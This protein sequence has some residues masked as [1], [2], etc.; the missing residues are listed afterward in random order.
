[1]P[2]ASTGRLP[3]PRAASR[4]TSDGEVHALEPRPGRARSQQRRKVELARGIMRDH[5]RWA[6][7]ARRMRRVSARVSTPDR[8]ILPSPGQ[9]VDEL[10]SARKLQWRGDGLAHDA[11]HRAATRPASTSS[12]LAPTLPICGKVKVMICA[13]VGRVGH[14]FLI[15]G[16]RG[17]EADFAHR[18]AERRRSL[19]PTCTVPSARTRTPVAPLGCAAEEAD[20]AIGSPNARVSSDGAKPWPLDPPPPASTSPPVKY[21]AKRPQQRLSPCEKER[22]IMLR[23][24][25]QAGHH[26]RDEGAATRSAP[27]ALPADIGQDQG[28]RHRAAHRP[29]SRWRTRRAGDRRCCRRWPSSAA[30]RSR[31]TRPAAARSSAATGVPN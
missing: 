31:C 21:V 8:P 19:C 3:S 10:R 5:A 11:A 13:G 20:R 14:D 12:A 26:H 29:T 6:R 23:E 7:R 18:L 2:P 16:H 9:P 25:D 24:R 17:V 27:R 22:E 15:A 1:M 4:L 28:Q 30:S